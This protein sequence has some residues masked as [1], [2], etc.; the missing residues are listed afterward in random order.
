MSAEIYKIKGRVIDGATKEGVAFAKIRLSDNKGN[1][2][3][4]TGAYTNIDGSFEIPVQGIPFTPP[5]LYVSHVGFA[6]QN[7]P[8]RAEYANNPVI[9]SLGSRLLDVVVVTPKDDKAEELK[10]PNWLLIAGISLGA[11]VIIGTTIYFATRNK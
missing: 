10:K 1:I 6:K 8:I 5:N 9:I 2:V 11:I 7:I 4:T 3:G